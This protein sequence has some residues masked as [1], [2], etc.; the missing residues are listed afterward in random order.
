ML[1]ALLRFRLGVQW[2]SRVKF[3]GF[4]GFG[5]L[6]LDFFG[7]LRFLCWT[8]L[9]FI[10]TCFFDFFCLLC[11]LQLKLSSFFSISFVSIPS[12]LKIFTFRW[13]FL[14]V[15]DLVSFEMAVYLKRVNQFFIAYQ[16]FG[17]LG[18]EA[19]LVTGFCFIIEV[20]SSLEETEDRVE[21][22]I[23]TV[24]CVLSDCHQHLIESC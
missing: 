4:N 1:A 16:S 18:R 20:S 21:E 5:F 19:H 23:D 22:A 13:K 11:L 15:L 9:L 12:L 2:E 10:Y 17:I 8:F 7:L 3:F 6:L 14:L 24:A